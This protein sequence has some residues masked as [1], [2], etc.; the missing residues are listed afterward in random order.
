MGFSSREGFPTATDDLDDKDCSL[1][2]PDERCSRK[3]TLRASGVFD[4]RFL[5]W[6]EEA[7]VNGLVSLSSDDSDHFVC[8]V[9]FC[10]KVLACGV[11]AQ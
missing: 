11:Y 2:M 4:G 5:T 7:Q 3:L 1:D 10:L 8:V 9:G 6:S